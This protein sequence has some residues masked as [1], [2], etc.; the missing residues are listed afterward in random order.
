MTALAQRIETEAEDASV[1][2]FAEH[3]LRLI[4]EDALLRPSYRAAA[5]RHLAR[6]RSGPGRQMTADDFRDG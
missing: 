1:A 3:L 5:R 2:A 4:A 6:L